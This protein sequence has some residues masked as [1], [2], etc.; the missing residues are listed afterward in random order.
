MSPILVNG[1]VLSHE[2]SAFLSKHTGMIQGLG[3]F[4]TCR[5][6]NGRLP[7]LSLHHARLKAA[8]TALGWKSAPG[9]ATLRAHAQKLL[10]VE[11]VNDGACKIILTPN[12]RGA[13]DLIVLGREYLPL[14][15]AEYRDGVTVS[16]STQLR[17]RNDSAYQFKSIGRLWTQLVRRGMENSYE[18]LVSNEDGEV[19]EGTFS[20]LILC[21][22]KQAI[23]PPVTSNLLAGVMRSWLLQNARAAGVA[24]QERPLREK[25]LYQADELFLCNALRGLVPVQRIGRRRLRR[26]PGP[27]A[28]LLVELIHK[29]MPGFMP[30]PD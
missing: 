20:N 3:L 21:R 17:S 6:L 7:L 23:T 25:D 29:K 27:A 5:V 4:E 8:A 9:M 19:C 28:R 24:L 26:S 10:H 12:A 13:L 1:S 18:T 22:A 11:N 2:A 16:L 15:A 30:K 14:P